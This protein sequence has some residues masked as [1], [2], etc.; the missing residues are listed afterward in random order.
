MPLMN[1]MTLLTIIG[2]LFCLVICVLFLSKGK[3]GS[4]TEAGSGV[5]TKKLY[6][7]AKQGDA[8]AQVAL[9]SMYAE[10]KGVPKN[11]REALKWLGLAAKQ[12]HANAQ[13]LLGIMY[14]SGRGVV[15]NDKEAVRLFRLSADQGNAGALSLL[16]LMYLSGQGVKKDGVE[17]LRLLR[18]SA[19]KGHPPSQTRLGS[20]YLEGKNVK[21]DE[22]EAAKWLGMAA[23]SGYPEAKTLLGKMSPVTVAASASASA[24]AAVPSTLPGGFPSFESIKAIHVAAEHGDADAQVKMAEMYLKGEVQRKDDKKAAYWLQKA[25]DQ[26][27]AVAKVMLAGMNAPKE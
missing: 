18:L 13:N 16:S 4:K 25:A 11:E 12:G 22:V 10:G 27:H 9:G 21:K 6:M 26:G 5:D 23:K 14:M 17:A 7:A 2:G 8:T 1:P 19:E 24:A 20:W 15:K 3:G